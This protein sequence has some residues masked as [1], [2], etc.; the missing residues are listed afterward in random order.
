MIKERSQEI[1]L[2]KT[3]LK[4]INSKDYKYLGLYKTD[5]DSED[6][7]KSY[8]NKISL[9]M[10]KYEKQKYRIILYEIELNKNIYSVMNFSHEFIFIHIEIKC[11][12]NIIEKKYKDYKENA[13]LKGVEKWLIKLEKKLYY[14]SNEIENLD[15]EQQKNHYEYLS[16]YY[17]IMFYYYAFFEKVNNNFLNSL[18]YLLLA[19]KIIKETLEQIT[20]PEIYR[21]IEKIYLFII[22]FY[23]FDKNFLS[24]LDYIKLLLE[25][26]YK[27]I[28]YLFLF[29]QNKDG[30]KIENNIINEILFII[31]ICFYYSGCIF[32]ELNNIDICSH[33]Y[34]Q[35]FSLS[36]NFFKEKYFYLNL[37]FKEIEKRYK[38]HTKI[39]SIISKFESSL[40]NDTDNKKD[41]ILKNNMLTH[42]NIKK[43]NRLKFIE[44]YINKLKIKEI[45]EDEKDL[46]SNEKRIKNKKSMR[47]MKQI[48]LLDY[49]TSDEFKPTIKKLDNLEINNI[50]DDTKNIIQKQIITIK[51]NQKHKNNSNEV[52]NQKTNKNNLV[53]FSPK[54]KT[55]LFHQIYKKVP[56]NKY[57][58][59]NINYKPKNNSNSIT[60]YYK[61]VNNSYYNKFNNKSNSNSNSNSFTYNNK[62]LKI[63]YDKYIFNKDYMKKRTF[64]ELQSEKEYK[65]QKEILRGKKNE[66][67]FIR[68]F[69][70]QSSKYK[71]E[72]FFNLTFEERLKSIEERN[73]SI[74]SEE[75]KRYFNSLIGK[76]ETLLFEKSC[77]SLSSKDSKKY[78]DFVK[79]IAKR[80]LINNKMFFFNSDYSSDSKYESNKKNKEIL[81]LLD[82]NITNIEKKKLKL[83]KNKSD[84]VFN[85]KNKTLHNKNQKPFY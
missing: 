62:P 10:D 58:Y 35:T 57:N 19:E 64:L 40:L 6:N 15:L 63:N 60:N 8:E 41:F 72:N 80:N 61:S 71:A 16:Y 1:L 55:K 4:T 3:F 56:N 32:E 84:R 12:I 11:I 38:K 14:Y 47:M 83:K 74:K 78:F 65:F 54:K 29:K 75:K 44:K 5:S 69:D 33:C 52:T 85:I 68:P 45:D 39:L 17:L 81:S 34:Y 2:S 25:I 70:I 59:S 31:V 26:C 43:K 82:L 24:A 18:S 66:Y 42:Y 67:I 37:L 13:Y 9:I 48:F 30:N 21:I 76:K 49:L 73:K 28:E 79:K 77:K 7:S 20:F 46:F 51:S 50:N 53:L 27:D 22:Y 36:N 23:M